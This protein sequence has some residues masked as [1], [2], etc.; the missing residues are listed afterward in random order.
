MASLTRVLL[1]KPPAP[2]DRASL[3][4]DYGHI[5]NELIWSREYQLN[6]GVNFGFRYARLFAGQFLKATTHG[7]VLQL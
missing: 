5:G 6:K 2:P 3:R 7:A 4:T 1:L